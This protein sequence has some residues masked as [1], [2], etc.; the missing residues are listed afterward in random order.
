MTEGYSYE[1]SDD[2]DSAASIE[3][4]NAGNDSY[5]TDK[6]HLTKPTKMTRIISQES[7][8]E[9]DDGLYSDNE[10]YDYDQAYLDNVLAEPISSQEKKEL[11][12]GTVPN[13]KYEC[14]TTQNIFENM[15]AKVNHLQP[16]FNIP[17]EDILILLQ[18]YDW[19]E[20]R[21]LE[22]WT[23]RM[24]DLLI[25]IGINPSHNT[26][27][28]QQDS[29]ADDKNS[30]DIIINTTRDVIFKNKFYCI[31]C[32]EEKST[33][34][35]ALECGHE[36][37]I[38]CYRHYI[39]DKLHSGN[40]INC[41]G[42]SLALKNEDIDKIM[43]HPS[44]TKLMLSSIKSFVSKHNRNYKW[45]PFADCN[46][47]IHLKDTSSLAEY[48]RLHYSPFVKCSHSHK[49]CFTCGFEMHAPADCN[50]TNAWVKKAKKES[51]NLNW[52]LSHT[53]ECPKCSVNIE[54]D[55]GCN[56]MKC[57]SCKYEFCWICEG[58][59][60]PH[61]KSFYQCTLYKNDDTNGDGT[62]TEDVAKTL[63]KYTFYYRMFNEHE[64][65]AKL[66]WKLG[67]TVG[68]KVKVLQ[69]KMGISWI[70]GQ[71][72]TDSIR[73]LNECRTALKWSFAVAFYSDASHNL[74]K[75]FV[76]NQ[77]LLSKAVED[78]SEL[79]QLKDPEVIM[80]KKTEFYNKTG[81]VENRTDALIECGRDL[82]CK[83]ICK[84]S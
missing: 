10:Y 61:G 34:T 53:K 17:S 32:C 80:A 48:S 79:L 50:I 74:T 21:L 6:D 2:D 1:Y 77:N 52:V 59:W 60:A 20:E 58:D 81:Y 24:D 49:F 43:G 13:L 16:I 44:S 76:D 18:H 3:L 33:E 56:H 68:N 23:E 54:K 8:F 5:L 70:E 19:N 72:L 42:C 40:I 45:C 41:M 64:V 29:T 30:N 63:K 31:I 83:G 39:E 51:E 26:S 28:N 15:L 55:G 78:L 7:G 65:S 82:L 57:S 71:F 38:D 25:E 12:K 69:E 66:D 35:F 4:Y 22:V 62:K 73:T 37:C 14:L 11:S 36:Y 67:Q 46:C 9:V 84:S 27:S 75:I 47:I